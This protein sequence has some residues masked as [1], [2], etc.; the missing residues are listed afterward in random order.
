VT[1]CLRSAIG[2]ASAAV[3]VAGVVPPAGAQPV[4]LEYRVVHAAPR[5]LQRRIDEAGRDGYT[6]AAV[7]RPEP[8]VRLNGVVVILSRPYMATTQVTPRIA[9]RV[10]LGTGSGGDLAEL[11]DRGAAQGY[12][13]CGIALAEVSPFPMMVAVMSPDTEGGI[14]HYAAEVLGNRDRVAR[15]AAKGREGFQPILATPVNDNRVVEQRNWMVVA[16][17]RTGEAQPVE[18]AIRSGPGPDSLEKAIV[19][20]SKQGYICSLLWKEGLTTIVVVMSR[21]PVDSTRRPEFRVDTIDPSR[22][23]GL[24]GVYI[25][26]VPHLS[27]GQRV[28]LTIRETSSTNYVVVDPLPLMGSLDYASLSDLRPLGEHLGRDRSRERARV[29]FSSV[30]RGPG[31][32]LILHT[33]FTRVSQ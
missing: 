3:V 4:R 31:G 33:V 17:Q 27:D 26:D 24:S 14:R 20:Q 18:I 25:G 6:C 2:I 8:D 32:G 23:D 21:L 22:L 19:E 7:A 10:V 30:R 5:E 28:V 15:L 16:E 12:R 13:L 11:L 29:R 1:R 9:H